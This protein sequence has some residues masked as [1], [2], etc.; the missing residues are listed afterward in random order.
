[1]VLSKFKKV[2]KYFL[3]SIRMLVKRMAAT[4]CE[5]TLDRSCRL[6]SNRQTSPHCPVT[7]PNFFLN[8][9]TFNPVHFL[10]ARRKVVASEKPMRLAI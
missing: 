1:M 5:F 8:S 4:K 6:F 7:H 3:L 10:K 9:L 2:K